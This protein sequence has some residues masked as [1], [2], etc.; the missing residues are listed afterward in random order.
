M[1][2]DEQVRQVHTQV[3]LIV[4]RHISKLGMALN[5]KFEAEYFR[6]T[7]GMDL[8]YLEKP[9]IKQLNYRAMD[10]YTNTLA[11]IEKLSTLLTALFSIIALSTVIMTLN[12][13]VII[14]IIVIIYVN[15]IAT[16]KANMKQYLINKEKSMFDRFLFGTTW[17]LREGDVGCKEIRLLNLKEMFINIVV[18]KKN[19]VNNLNLKGITI[20]NKT[21]AFHAV[22]NFIQELA[23]YGY[24]IYLV[25]AKG[26]AVG[27]LTIYLTAVGR[28]AD[29]MNQIMNS[30][31]ELAKIS[32]DVQDFKKFMEIPLS[33]QVSGDKKPFLGKES[34]IEFK[35]VSF[36][37][38]NSDN[39][40]IKNMN[41]KIHSNEKLCIVG[42][43]GSGKS[44]FI[45]LLTRFYKPTEGEILLNGVNV[46][47]YDFVDYQG[48]F[49]PVFQ[50]FVLYYMTVGE[51]IVLDKTYD[52]ERLKQIGLKSGISEL[53]EKLPTGY[54]TNIY[55]FNQWDEK[56][57]FT[58]SGG[59]GQRIA[60]AR[61]VYH[62]SLIY[63]L[64]EP[65]A[66]LDPL[67]EHEIY[68]QFNEM[69]TN[70]TVVL[71]THRLSAVQLA[72]KVAVFDNGELI[73][74]GTHRQLYEK[75]GVYTDMFS[76]QSKF[77]REE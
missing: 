56:N 29:S 14:L 61:A 69:T 43:N 28:L 1:H 12:P 75:N 31:L 44:T 62:D 73:E 25:I 7:L 74:Y 37:Y 76:K 40:A 36:K 22:M 30:Y 67:A 38:P 32:L 8:E 47:E 57:S 53:V 35:N 26:L 3:N 5:L 45:K 46:A 58:P 66:A 21:S 18:E 70:K 2:V 9:E 77:Y 64:D 17:S 33:S 42:A 48:L 6:H 27:S 72:D 55:S 60:I 4:N 15:S 23:L 13:V 65:T 54:N 19:N 10:T 20:N 71:I 16:K 49:S 24:L 50:D 51:N 11:I 63:L 68:M 34:I 59:E 39:Y 52:E 41:I